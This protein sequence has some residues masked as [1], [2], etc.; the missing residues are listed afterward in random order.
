[1][2]YPAGLSGE[3]FS[4]DISSV[5]GQRL[6]GESGFDSW[7]P[8]GAALGERIGLTDESWRGRQIFTRMPFAPDHCGGEMDEA[9]KVGG[10]PVVAGLG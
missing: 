10:S 7:L 3:S 6:T 1:M 5:R 8:L 2:K 4:T 9:G